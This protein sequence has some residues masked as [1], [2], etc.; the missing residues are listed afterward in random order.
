MDGA[1]AKFQV[2]QPTV[3]VR[4]WLLCTL[5][6]LLTA[7]LTTWIDGGMDALPP[8]ALGCLTSLA[9]A[10]VWMA[11]AAG[12][13]SWLG[14]WMNV[15]GVATS[16]SAGVAAL[17]VIDQWCGTMGLLSRG[18]VV[19]LLTLAPGWWLLARRPLTMRVPTL[20]TWSTVPIGIACGTLLAAAM[21]PAGFLWSTEFGGYDALSYHL[22][23]PREWMQAGSMRPLEHVAYAG[24]PN[25]V[26]GAFMH[27]MALRSDPRDAAIACQ[28]LHAC[29]LLVAAGTLAETLRAEG[30]N[31][32]SR[33]C[34]GVALLATPWV[35][36]TGSLAYSESG[37]LL[38][39]ALAMSAITLR[40]RWAGGVA[41]GLGVGA[42]IG[43]K[44]SSVTLAV[45]SALA[46]ALVMGRA[47]IDLR[48]WLAWIGTAS[49]SLFP[50]LL[51]NAWF[52]AAPVFP[53]LCAE[54]GLGWWKPVQAA[55]WDAAHGSTAS[56]TQR[57]VALWQQ[58][59]AFGAGANPREGEPWRWLWGPLPWIGLASTTF[60]L[61]S[62]H[63]RRLGVA[64][65]WMTGLTLVG[66][67][68]TTHLQSRFLVPVAVPLAV[69]TGVAMGAAAA[70]QDTVRRLTMLVCLCWSFVAAWA[71]VHD[72]GGRLALSGR[73]DVASGALDLEMLASENDAVVESV[74]GRPGV[75]ATVSG[76]F[77]GQRILSVGWSTPFW[78]PPDARVWWSTV[79]DRSVLEDALAQ[80]DPL[81]WLRERFDLI[82]LDEPM[83]RRWQRSGWL[84][85]DL[86]PGRLR[87]LLAGQDEMPLAGGRTLISLGDRLKPTWPERRH[88]DAVERS[89]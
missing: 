66:W 38:G 86:D 72:A 52:T 1:A 28:L 75:E 12:L 70:A 41:F 64:L 89:Y 11:S 4:S 31:D 23:V 32:W 77:K 39:M 30:V 8:M 36:V 56:L 2:P 21:V 51:R 15:R 65:A 6:A 76:L 44:A 3:R 83:L 47:R 88:H 80:P 13:G 48:W 35:I 46:W 87:S 55:R 49:V 71:L 9:L 61:G 60:L 27:L 26:E 84:S 79:W 16:V 33:G 59:L 54:F 78:L 29:M 37:V 82:L 42:M 73:V 34:A 17:L 43:S 19:P 5:V 14:G 10:L 50:W 67:M 24:F 68:F 53:L 7:C 57:A 40:S 58:W 63:W 22:Q 45:P 81:A 25:F 69:A 18:L 74:R 20:P 62:H 85:P